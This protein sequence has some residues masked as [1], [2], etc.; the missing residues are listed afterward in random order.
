MSRNTIAILAAALVLSAAVSVEALDLNEASS[1]FARGLGPVMSTAKFSKRSHLESRS[2][3]KRDQTCSSGTYYRTYCTGTT[4]CAGAN[5]CINYIWLIVGLIFLLISICGCVRRCKR[6]PPPSDNQ[7]VITAETPAQPYQ[8]NMTYGGQPP[9]YPA[10][11]PT[12]TYPPLAA[13]TPASYPALS[14]APPAPYYPEQQGQ[15][16]SPYAQ[17]APYA[18][19]APSP[20]AQ[21]APGVYAQPAPSPY[22]QPAPSPYTQPAPPANTH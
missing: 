21:P 19:S 3:H 17:Q 5:T 6:S 13:P 10:A 11:Y 18:Q 2:L 4:F 20:Y 8:P 15:V 9:V 1:Y 22:T 14:P 7:V 16:S 12:A